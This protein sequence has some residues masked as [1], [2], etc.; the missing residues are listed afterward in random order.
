MKQARMEIAEI[1]L[2]LQRQCCILPLK[3]G[4][5]ATMLHI[6]EIAHES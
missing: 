6:L 1:S 5:T 4:L 3:A 2:A